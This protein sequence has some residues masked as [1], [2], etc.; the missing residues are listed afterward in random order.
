MRTTTSLLM[1]SIV[2][3][4]VVMLYA[5]QPFVGIGSKTGEVTVAGT[6]SIYERLSGKSPNEVFE[7]ID[8]L[9]DAEFNALL[10]S[11]KP[12]FATAP[13]FR[14]TPDMSARLCALLQRSSVNG[15]IEPWEFCF[16]EPFDAGCSA[17]TYC[18]IYTGRC[19]S[20]Q[21]PCFLD[22][23]RQAFERGG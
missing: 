14:C 12:R 6:E 7:A 2:S 23:A 17:A 11:I 15:Q 13:P 1:V 21:G 5:L 8:R 9:S 20:S 4:A 18:D 3:A 16:N 10:S 22:Q 19:Q